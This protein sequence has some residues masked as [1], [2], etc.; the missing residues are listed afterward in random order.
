MEQKRDSLFGDAANDW[1]DYRRTN[2]EE[3]GESDSETEKSE[4]NRIETLLAE[5]DPSR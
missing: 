1:D 5:L 3:A 4:L 2:A